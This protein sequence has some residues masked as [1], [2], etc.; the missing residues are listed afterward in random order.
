MSSSTTNESDVD[1][2]RFRNAWEAYQA[3]DYATSLKEFS[4]LA[5]KGDTLAWVYLGLLHKQGFGVPQDYGKA[6]MCFNHAIELGD[7][8][9][10]V[11]LGRLYSIRGTE[12]KAFDCFLKASDRGNLP[13][14]Y[15]T[16]R[17]YLHGFGTKKDIEKAKQYLIMAMDRGHVYARM[18][19]SA[20]QTK[21]FFGALQIIPGLF[22]VVKAGLVFVKTFRSDPHGERVLR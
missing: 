15:W 9:A 6:E 20:A 2:R 16:G 5:E 17:A 19:Y 3:A 12:E 8:F 10:L 14:M 13:G 21:G 18:E 1:Q 22:G 11:K 7:V 4:A